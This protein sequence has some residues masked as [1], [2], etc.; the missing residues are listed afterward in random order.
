MIFFNRNNCNTSFVMKICKKKGIDINT[1]WSILKEGREK[2]KEEEEEEAKS[3]WYGHN[4][5]FTNT[6]I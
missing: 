2:V 5:K 1:L 3:G 4:F 6:R